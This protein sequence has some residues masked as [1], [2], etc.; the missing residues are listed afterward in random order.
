MDFLFFK[1]FYYLG[2]LKN[3]QHTLFLSI[4]FLV[5]ILWGIRQ[6]KKLNLDEVKIID[7][8]ITI[9]ISSL[10]GA[11]LFHVFYE[12]PEYYIQYPLRIFAIWQGGF[13][14]YGGFL[15]AILASFIFVKIKKLPIGK[16]ADVASMSIP[17]GLGIGR[18]GCALA[19]CCYGR[20][21]DFFWGIKYNI[22]NNIRPQV[23]SINPELI[24][25]PLH[26][27]QLLMSGY[28]FLIFMILYF[29]R[30][31]Q[32]F[33]GELF[34]MFGILYSVFRF[35]VEFLR[36]DDRGSEIFYLTISQFI[37][38]GLFVVSIILYIINFS[39]LK[40]V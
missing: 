39:K 7:L 1:I 13:V 11:R 6:A 28:N 18:I 9:F 25:V 37:S 32:K 20:P 29:Y 40:K 33:S 21:T 36:A 2:P 19:G 26:P 15:F 34:I 30:K 8:G 4:G 31:K 16:V 14:Y 38:I 35:F 12:R 10:V 5:A 3:S 23:I 17:L 24:N 22:I 27:T